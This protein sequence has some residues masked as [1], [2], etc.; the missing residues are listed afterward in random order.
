M[1]DM[2]SLYSVTEVNSA[3]VAEKSINVGIFCAI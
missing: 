1:V 3:V 2:V